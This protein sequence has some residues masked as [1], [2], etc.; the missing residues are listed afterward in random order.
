MAFSCELVSFKTLKYVVSI[1]GSFD[2]DLLGDQN[3]T[4]ERTGVNYMSCHTIPRRLLG[5]PFSIARASFSAFSEAK[6]W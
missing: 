3:P 2:A 5:I 6:P 4:P 1:S